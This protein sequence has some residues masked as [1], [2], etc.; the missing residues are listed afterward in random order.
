MKNKATGR[1]GPRALSVL[2]NGEVLLYG[3]IGDDWDGLDSAAV[4]RDIDALGEIP[5]LHIRINSPG[6]FIYEGLAI[7]NYLVA[8]SA[9]VIVHIDSLAAS[10]ASVIAMAGDQIIMPPNAS[11]MI[12][13]PWDVAFGEADDF[14]KKADN[15]D[16]LKDQI[17]GIYAARTG[18]DATRL[19]EL[20]D[21]ETW[22]TAQEAVADG[23]ADEIAEADT[24]S[25]MQRFD[26]SLF[27]NVPETVS[28]AVMAGRDSAAAMA[29]ISA[30]HE[31]RSD[32]MPKPNV[33]NGTAPAGAAN[34][35]P[36]VDANDDPQNTI[37]PATIAK[38]AIAKE[39]TRVS[40]IQA[41]VRAAKLDNEFANDL[42]AKGVSIDQARAAII[43]KWADA[44]NTPEP[45]N[46]VR[47][48]VVSD[49]VDR[50][51][52]GATMALMERAGLSGGERNEFTGLNLRELARESLNVRN[53]SSRGMPVMEMAGMAFSPRNFGHHSTSDFGNIL[54]DV[55]NKSM[56][57]G[58]EEAEETFKRWTAKGV[59]TDF[60]PT[61]RVDLNLFDNLLE[62]GEGAEYK[63]GTIGDRGETVMLATYGRKFSI[64]RQAIIN[65]DIGAFTRVP[66]KMGRAAIR[67][68][69]NLVYA[70]LTGNP[71]LSDGVALFH[72]SHNNLAG[73]GAAP[74]TATLD[75]GRTA[76]ATQ[77]D[78]DDKAAGGLNIQP[79]Y[80][81]VPAALRGT[82]E[83]A[84]SSEYDT[85]KGDKKLPNSIRNMAEVISEARLDTDS[86]TAWYLAANPN[87][88][89]TIEVNY[90]DGMD[91]PYLENR[92]GWDIDGVEMK[93]RIDASPSVLG[94]RGLYKNAGA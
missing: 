46:H 1:P 44:D 50:F 52:Q 68:V 2:S 22:M 13:N 9:K 78:P 87:T 27:N 30:G 32:Q 88:A 60:K 83:T 81:L 24:A 39:R 15:L 70:I 89:D 36:V 71:T 23:F 12:H 16:R 69:G 20:M 64:T 67:T 19:S 40:E 4:I 75:A 74:S 3:V 93:V 92:D 42:I 72:S 90:L 49:G 33:A 26:L 65:D 73:S 63:Y 6:G 76:M 51:R 34:P 28:G 84:I 14:R 45:T 17:V 82:M 80:A 25:A 47:A 29:D 11:M 86:S 5:E 7:Y 48:S 53:I 35:T 21:V 37:D 55:A 94:Y 59:L 66:R 18:Q 43:D 56:L 54:A 58:Y 91:T 31:T 10:M 77:K 8:H 57:I 85:A 41:A 79:A 62:V 61:K 38:E